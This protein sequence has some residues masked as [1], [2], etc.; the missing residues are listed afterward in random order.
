MLTALFADSQEPIQT[1]SRTLRRERPE[2]LLTIHS[3]QARRSSCDLGSMQLTVEQLWRV[4]DY[5]QQDCGRADKTRTTHR[6]GRA[7]HVSCIHLRASHHILTSMTI[8]RLHVPCLR[9]HRRR[10]RH[11]NQRPRLP[12]ARRPP[13]SNQDPR[14]FPN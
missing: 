9:P 3:Q 4:H 12:P 13:T 11:H 6:C 14:R 5:V 1:R 7:R 2:L 8:Y 10:L